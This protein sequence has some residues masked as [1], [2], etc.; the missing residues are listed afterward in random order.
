[1]VQEQLQDVCNADIADQTRWIKCKYQTLHP[2]I[3]SASKFKNILLLGS[4]SAD[5]QPDHGNGSRL[6]EVNL[7]LWRYGRGQPRTMSIEE[8][9]AARQDR[10]SEARIRAEETKKRSRVVAAR[11]A[12]ERAAVA[13]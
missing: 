13:D 10:V 2:I 9:E 7:W 6:Y 1:M 12:A 4:A 11:E 5:T 8:V 3:H